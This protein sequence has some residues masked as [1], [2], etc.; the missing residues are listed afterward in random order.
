MY[1]VRFPDTIIELVQ[2]LKSSTAFAQHSITAENGDMEGT[3]VGIVEA[4][5]AG[6]PVISTFHA[7]I[8]DV[9]NNRETGLLVEEHDVEEME[10]MDIDGNLDYAIDY[11]PG[12]NI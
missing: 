4:S 8:P 1:H 2:H 5:Y 9:I 12:I 11:V 7:G 6:L 3:P 10:A